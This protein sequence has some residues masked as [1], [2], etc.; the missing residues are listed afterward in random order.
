MAF[1]QVL[2]HPVA[3]VGVVGIDIG[4]GAI[5]GLLVVGHVVAM[6][7]RLVVSPIRWVVVS[8]IS[9]HWLVVT[10]ARFWALIVMVVG[11]QGGSSCSQTSNT[12]LS[13][14]TAWHLYSLTVWRKRYTSTFE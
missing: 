4:M 11:G 1:Y 6:I 7:L 2:R 14:F 13:F 8:G 3:G 12:W 10:V 5:I 9:H